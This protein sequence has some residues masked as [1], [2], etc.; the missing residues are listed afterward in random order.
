MLK[1]RG[2]SQA[3]AYLTLVADL[4]PALES[5]DSDWSDVDASS[6]DA[7]YACWRDAFL[8]TTSPMTSP[9]DGR[10]ILL[11]ADPRPRVLYAGRDVAAVLRVLWLDEAA[12][13][14]ELRFIGRNPIFRGQRLGDRAL[15]EAFRVLHRMGAR[16]VQLDVASNNRAALALYDRWKFRRTGQEEVFRIALP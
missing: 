11:G 10:A 14:G 1:M 5:P 13:A 7:A 4:P 2:Y 6:V 12:R 15:S 16:S 8:E 9:E 3:Y